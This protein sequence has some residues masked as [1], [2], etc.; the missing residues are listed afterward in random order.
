MRKIVYS[1]GAAALLFLGSCQDDAVVENPVVPAVTGDEIT[2]GSSLVNAEIDTESDSRTVYGDEAVNG[3][4][5]VYWEADGSDQIAIYC[6]QASNGTMVNYKVTPDAT[7]ATHSSAVTKVNAEQAG[8]QWGDVNTT[9]CFSAFYPADKIKGSEN[10]KLIGEIPVDQSPVAWKKTAN[11][12]G[13]YTYTGVANTDYAFMWAYNEHDPQQGGDVALTFHP[14]VT[15]LDVEI[16]GPANAGESVKMSS[17]QLRAT[18]YTT[19]TGDFIIDFTDVEQNPNDPNAA[20]GYEAYGSTSATRS[21]LSIQLYADKITED[22]VESN[23]DDFITLNH[24]DKIVVRF[25]LLPKDDNYDTGQTQNLELRVSPFNSS[26]LV[27][28]LNAQ[29]NTQD[30][31][32]LAHKVNKVI[33]PPVSQAGYNYWMSSLNPGIFVTELSLPGS[34][35]S[36]QNPTD[37]SGLNTYYQ[38]LSVQNQIR[39]GIRAFHVQTYGI[40]EDSNEPSRNDSSDETSMTLG[41]SVAEKTTDITF[42][43]MVRTVADGLKEAENYDKN[44]EYAF[45]LLTY[46]GN[47]SK[48]YGSEWHRQ[49]L[50]GYYDWA[51]APDQAWMQAVKN[52]LAEMAKDD[53]TY[54]L[55]TDE[56]TS[57]TTLRD[58]AGHVIIKVNYNSDAMANHLATTDRIPA[59][60]SIWGYG[61]QSDDTQGLPNSTATHANAYAMNNLRWGTSNHSVS[62]TMQ[63]FYHEA[64]SIGHNDNGGEETESE[65]KFRVEDMW[66][67]SINYYKN[68]D[69]HS[70]WFM[71]DLGGYYINGGYSGSESQGGINGWTQEI[72]PIATKHLQNRTEDATLGIVLLNYADPSNSYSGNLIQTIINNNF[73]FQLRTDG[74]TQSETYNATYS[75][76][77]NAIGW[78]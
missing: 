31:G 71:N 60:F 69:S 59:L 15:I 32:I 61:S 70:M 65:K 21:Q 38:S 12:A 39:N 72:G 68:N 9:H 40:N 76:G 4:Y 75:N 27:R 37:Q 63:F 10:G 17:V 1:L 22:G 41:V 51:V 7:D 23:F 25:F 16:N 67:R 57:S 53:N 49:G 5:P 77:G 50:G 47:A 3:A 52:D 34:K 42:K 45:I 29:G 24:G 64:S 46:T 13:G 36:Y 2:F 78:E 14:W 8:L 20:P 18:D 66:N 55:Y 48:G 33:L 35:F 54:R 62:S 56:I 74:S 19:L 30:G 73:N 44:G 6:P 28:T 11:D 26:V 43:D 58:L